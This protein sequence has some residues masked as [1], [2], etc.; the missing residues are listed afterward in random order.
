MT[1]KIILISIKFYLKL[2]GK[3]NPLLKSK[4]LKCLCRP[5]F[6]VVKMQRQS[7][8]RPNN[9]TPSSQFSKMVIKSFYAN[10]VPAVPLTRV[11]HNPI[12]S[13][14]QIDDQVNRRRVCVLESA[15]LHVC[16]FG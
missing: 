15:H 1:L 11:A 3:I 9:S 13:R 14:S 10:T 2:I 6:L 7:C 5:E 12:L 4:A 8:S 16:G